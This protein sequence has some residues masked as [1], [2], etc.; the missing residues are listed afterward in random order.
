MSVSWI[1]L[2]SSAALTVPTG[3]ANSAAMA[4]GTSHQ[5]RGSPTAATSA[6]ASAK[7]RN[8]RWVPASGISS[9]A[10]R[11]VPS[12]EPTV[13]IAYMRPA[14]SPESS[15]LSS[16]SR[17]A[18]GETAPSISTGI[19]TSASTPSSEPKPAP[20]ERSSNALTLIER[21]GCETI[22]TSASSAAATSTSR[23][24]APWSGRRSAIRPPNQ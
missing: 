5:R 21:N 24:S 9:S 22:G 17:I 20:S 16:F 23:L 4:S 14:V 10:E 6:S 11:N 2:P 1:T 7:V 3:T 13:E 12:S 15:M 18:H 19:A 8:V